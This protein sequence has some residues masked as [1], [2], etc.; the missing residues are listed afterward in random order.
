MA[1][2][3]LGE[4][5]HV[6]QRAGGDPG[7]CAARGHGQGLQASL[8]GG[9][10][11]PWFAA[12]SSR[13]AVLVF[14]ELRHPAGVWGAVQGLRP[15]VPSHHLGGPR[16]GG[17]G[18]L[19]PDGQLPRPERDQALPG[20]RPG[21]GSRVRQGGS[22][23]RGRQEGRARRARQAVGGARGHG[24]AGSGGRG[25]EGLGRRHRS[26]SRASHG[27]RSGQRREIRG[28]AKDVGHE[29]GG[30]CCGREQIG[31]QAAPGAKQ[32]KLGGGG[33]WIVPPAPE[34]PWGGEIATRVAVL[35]L[36]C[37]V[38]FVALQRSV[39]LHG[40]LV[41]LVCDCCSAASPSPSPT[42]R[43]D[44]AD[45]PKPSNTALRGARRQHAH[46]DGPLH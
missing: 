3:E 10:Q 8:P 45:A 24:G 6:P 44:L 19:E 22:G 46:G 34:A 16:Q 39:G 20:H 25:R 40:A 30:S 27:R 28:G 12:L 5:G 15:S 32:A 17:D 14:V 4:A 36:P 2:G 26:G 9:W 42:Q 11:V 23:G 35:L 41:K 7:A 31:R 43:R 38:L 33:L 13:R 37:L 21:L 1:L 18:A 29:R